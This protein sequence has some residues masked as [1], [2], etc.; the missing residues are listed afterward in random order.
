MSSTTA[1]LVQHLPDAGLVSD[2]EDGPRAVLRLVQLN[3][4]KKKAVMAEMGQLLLESN[5]DGVML[6]EPNSIRTLQGLP[7]VYAGFVSASTNRA[8]ST[9]AYTAVAARASLQPMR[10]HSAEEKWGS[11]CSFHWCGVDIYVASVY[12]PWRGPIDEYVEVIERFRR[13]ADGAPFIVGLDANASHMLW[14]SKSHG[15]RL[16]RERTERGATLASYIAGAGLHVLNRPSVHYTYAGLGARRAVSDIDVTLVNSRWSEMFDTRWQLL[17]D[18]TTSDHNLIEVVATRRVL[19][20]ATSPEVDL[21]WNTRRA[22]WRMYVDD[23]GA[24]LMALG[25]NA[26][27]S[28]E[29]QVELIHA[30]VQ[31]TNDAHFPR[32][33]ARAVRSTRWWTHALSLQR[34]AVRRARRHW[35]RARARDSSN[36]GELGREYHRKQLEYNR[37]ILDAKDHHWRQFVGDEGN[38][39]PWGHVYR[40]CRGRRKHTMLSAIKMADGTLTSTRAESVRV[41]L[42]SF[43]PARPIDSVDVANGVDPAQVSVSALTH[44]EVDVAVHVARRDK[45]PGPDGLTSSI[46]RRLWLAAPDT[47]LRLFERCRSEGV[48]PS[49]WKE[50]RLVILPKSPDKD[51]TDPRTYRPICLLSVL[52]KVLERIMVNRLLVRVI[53]HPRQFGFTVGRGTE[54]ALLLATAQTAACV[55]KYQLGIFVDFRGAF[56]NL[57]WDQV[58]QKISTTVVDSR[59]WRSYFSDRSVFVRNGAS[60]IRHEV[61]RGCPQGSICGPAVW[62][63]MMGG[64]LERLEDAGSNCIAYA[65]DLLLLISGDSRTQ[66]E[67]ASAQQL[68]IVARWGEEVGVPVNLQKT[69][70]MLLKGRLSASRPPIV[71]LDGS[72]IAYAKEI[73]Y[74]GVTFGPNW[75][76]GRHVAELDRKSLSTV[77]LLR[78]VL[79]REWGL[80]LATTLHIYRGL[81]VPCVCYGSVVWAKALCTTGSMQASILRAQRTALY[82]MLCVCRTVSTVAMQVLA[83][84]LPWDLEVRRSIVMAKI[85][86]D[87]E[88]TD[89]DL[90]RYDAVQ[91]LSK[92]QRRMVVRGA[93]IDEWQRRWDGESRGRTTYR[94]IPDVRFV[95]ESKAFHASLELTYLLTGKGSLNAHLNEIGKSP[96]AACPSC[97]LA[98]ETWQH[99]LVDCPAYADIRCL[100]DWHITIDDDGEPEVGRALLDRDA[101]RRLNAF[102][103]EAFRRR[104]VHLLDLN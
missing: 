20:A 1:S 42:E 27:Q 13:I 22:D 28:I 41:L 40:F 72:S 65:D 56:D 35:Q 103:N 47:V 31:R 68:E 32:V 26:E 95:G 81:F 86:R 96:T 52:G 19:G 16:S 12:C 3:C 38:A 8:R 64:L 76:F 83:G 92:K 5:I 2:D 101:V 37:S 85:R 7:S 98:D 6:Q 51:A 78:R 59:L 21:R 46:V 50:S 84:E 80:S 89:D 71:R 54:D 97:R 58:L 43:F 93:F 67:R 77:G 69:S 55:E 9:H 53:P 94:W 99:V 74:L 18:R 62:N 61:Q 15:Q 44:D 4:A 36:V 11:C 91:G 24:R 90:V 39:H 75:S 70:Q 34:R 17:A 79:R 88:L 102:A 100:S 49:C 57:R 73:R 87:L 33:S 23:M 82:A 66:L 63:L 29:E 45:T 30:T 104:K 25:L 48:F 14:H 60:V 10:L